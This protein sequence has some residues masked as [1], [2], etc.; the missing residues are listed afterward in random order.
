MA[1]YQSNQWSTC[2]YFAKKAKESEDFNKV[3]AAENAEA[4]GAQAHIREITN[5]FG[6]AQTYS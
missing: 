1:S 5:R 6:T 2:R 4:E 3:I